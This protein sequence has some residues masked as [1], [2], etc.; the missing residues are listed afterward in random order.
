MFFI[1]LQA[2]ILLVV[3]RQTV[4]FYSVLLPKLRP[5]LRQRHR[6]SAD[7]M[8]AEFK[9]FSGFNVSTKNCAPVWLGLPWPSSCS[10]PHTAPRI[11]F[12]GVKKRRRTISE[13]Q[14]HVLR[15][16]KSRRSIRQSDGWVRVL[17]HARLTLPAWLHCANCRGWWETIMMDVCSSAGEEKH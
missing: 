13:K 14:K 8:T 4:H 17:A 5:I 10:E 2:F 6:P 1:D 12:N 16:D 11:R 15:S 7:S 3:K 9:T